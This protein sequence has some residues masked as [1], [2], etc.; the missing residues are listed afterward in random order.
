MV[1]NGV[2]GNIIFS[3]ELENLKYTDS[4]DKPHPV[5]ERLIIP[6]EYVE[7]QLIERKSLYPVSAIQRNQIVTVICIT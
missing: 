7:P 4:E 2:S 6:D 5:I 1:A 3:V